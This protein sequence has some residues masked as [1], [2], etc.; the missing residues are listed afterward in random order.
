MIL[1]FFFSNLDSYGSSQLE[2]GTVL[3][4]IYISFK[5]C[6]YIIVIVFDWVDV[7]Y[8]FFFAGGGYGKLYWSS[9]DWMKSLDSGLIDCLLA[10]PAIS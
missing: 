10:C 6:N 3:M 7:L 5:F 1:I 2:S 8:Y 9:G 4:I